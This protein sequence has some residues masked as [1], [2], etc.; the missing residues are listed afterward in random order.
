M[1]KARKYIDFKL[2][3]S[4]G[5]G[6][7][8]SY[9]VSLLPTPEVGE[10]VLP[11]PFTTTEGAYQQNQH[12]LQ[13]KNITLFNIALVGKQ[14]SDWILPQGTIR[15]LFEQALAKAG[16]QGGVRLRLIIADH[17]LKQ[18]PWEFA[19]NP[20]MPEDTIYS[21][22]ALDPRI[23]IVRHEPLGLPHRQPIQPT[24]RMTELRMLVA[25]ATPV[26]RK[27]LAVD[28][29]V[30]NLENALNSIKA[31]NLDIKLTSKRNATWDVVTN[32]LD[33]PNKYHIF[34]FAGHGIVQL[35][36]NNVN[37]EEMEMGSLIF[38][39]ENNQSA[40]ISAASFADQMQ[41]ADIWLVALGAC[42]TGERSSRSPWHSVAGAL[43]NHN[44]PVVIAMQNE[45]VDS[46]A[47]TFSQEFYGKLESGLSLDEAMSWSRRK[48]A[49][50]LLE[51]LD[52]EDK[53]IEWGLPVLYS[54]LPDGILVP[55][56]VERGS[57][58]ANAARGGIQ[59]E[60][61]AVINI[62]QA[63]ENVSGNVI[64]ADADG[65]SIS[66]KEI[67]IKQTVKKVESGGTVTGFKF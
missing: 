16:N 22:L 28:K 4:K 24:A 37:L 21:F 31:A 30:E 33:Q 34:H 51:K 54:R 9:Q 48:M 57:D 53:N 41:Q 55:D 12:Y 61:D 67:N 15:N 45:I 1:S 26:D 25:A 8:G 27:A 43:L 17:T 42:D 20:L 2:Y 11:V 13:T 63:F 3:L 36:E 38:V 5:P 62:E 23:S 59:K 56:F 60:I 64:G 58:D 18:I 50:N 32:Q 7:E 39:D 66:G 14:L 52:T 49:A 6:G 29:E 44:I 65:K 10:S 46:A 47:K 19:R 40:P 35:V